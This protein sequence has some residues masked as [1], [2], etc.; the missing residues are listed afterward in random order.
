MLICLVCIL[1]AT[2]LAIDDTK[3]VVCRRAV[4]IAIDRGLQGFFGVVEM[5]C[6]CLQNSEIDPRTSKRWIGG[7]QR[8]ESL[9]SG[10]RVAGA[11]VH[12]SFIELLN[13]L[14]RQ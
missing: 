12:H 10:S 8:L 11:H 1:E 6:L 13:R 7:C 9:L 4:C 14:G 2:Q 3:L 5:A